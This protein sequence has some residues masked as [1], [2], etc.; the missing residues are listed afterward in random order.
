MWTREERYADPDAALLRAGNAWLGEIWPE[1]LRGLVEALPGP[2]NRLHA[3]AAMAAADALIVDA[4][5][6]AGWRVGRQR[7]RFR[8]VRGNLDFVVDGR[9]PRPFGHTYRDLAGMNLVAIANG[10]A[11][12]DE[13][14]VIVA[15]HDTVRDSPGADDNGAAVALL[16][17]LAARLAGRRF[18]RTVILATPDL[19]EIGFLGSG[20]LVRWLRRH[21]RVRGAVV[22]DPIGYMD[23]RPGSERIPPGIGRLYP[24]QLARVAAG[25]YRGDSVVAIYRRRSAELVREW[26]RCLAATLG[27]ERI[28]L[29]RAPLDL[30]LI[31]PS[32]MLHPSARN[33]VRSDHV[34]FWSARLPA[35]HVTDTAELR[36]PHY[37]RPT[38][39]PDTLDYETLARIGAATALL[40]ERLAR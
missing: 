21:Y 20:A 5:R 10:A 37:H 23:P 26:A 35:I 2:R 18:G 34:S 29:L 17:E 4:W 19:E 22:L 25:G 11:R 31:G 38:D 12:P 1:R 14:L 28:V 9:R 15:H 36:N 13:A 7:L 3:P 40:I 39:T 30:P 8:S 16:L 33:F 32:L 6:A 24:E 27:R